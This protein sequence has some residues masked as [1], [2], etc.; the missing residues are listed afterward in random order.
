MNDIASKTA[1]AMNLINAIGFQAFWNRIKN[2]GVGAQFSVSDVLGDYVQQIRS[3]GGNLVTLGKLI[4]NNVNNG[5]LSGI[6]PLNTIKGSAQKY[7]VTGPIKLKNYFSV[8]YYEK[9]TYRS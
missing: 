7:I 8:P 4:R 1:S 3:A 9:K 2:Y 6:Q 5:N